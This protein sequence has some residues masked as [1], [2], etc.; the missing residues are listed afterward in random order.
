MTT[1]GT[2]QHSPFTSSL[3]NLEARWCA[4]RVR[5]RCERMAAGLLERKGIRYY[6][7]M[8]QIVRQYQR[9][10]RQTDR[11][12]LPGYVLVQI[13]LGDYVPVLDTL[14]VTGFVRLDNAPAIIPQAEIDLLAR[15]ANSGRATELVAVHDLHIGDEIE[16]IGG[17]LTGLKGRLV[18]IKGKEFLSVQL[19]HTEHALLLDIDRRYI[20]NQTA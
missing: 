20:R 17:D 9:K 4:V 16:V 3:T 12:L 1:Q 13:R 18:A 14:H 19:L 11:L 7:P 8:Q 2:A 15:V 10:R 6:L 5:A